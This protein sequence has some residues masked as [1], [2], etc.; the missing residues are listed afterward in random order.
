MTHEDILHE[1]LIFS[2]N[3]PDFG[4]PSTCTIVAIVDFGF[5]KHP[6]S[7]ICEL[8]PTLRVQIQFLFISQ[9]RRKKKIRN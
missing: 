2:Q 6:K 4:M 3:N 5:N 9:Y 1:K 7:Y 8:V